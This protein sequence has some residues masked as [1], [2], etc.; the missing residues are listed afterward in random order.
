MPRGNAPSKVDQNQPEI[1]AALRKKGYFVLS[2]AALGG[3]VPDLLVVSR[4]DG[5][6]AMLMEVK[7]GD[8][9]LNRNEIKWHAA[10][11]GRRAIVR[12][13]ERAVE[14]MQEFDEETQE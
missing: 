3:G 2:L 1:V 12:N 13:S 4:T 5:A 11:P 7:F 14:I 10:Y 6:R 8:E 9:P